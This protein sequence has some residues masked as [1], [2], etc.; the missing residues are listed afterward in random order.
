MGADPEQGRAVLDEALGGGGAA[1]RPGNSS[2]N[3][4]DRTLALR[5]TTR[6][7]QRQRSVKLADDA[8]PSLWQEGHHVAG[9]PTR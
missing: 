4:W 1:L 3:F 9:I 7:T 2:T 8:N 5:V 6:V